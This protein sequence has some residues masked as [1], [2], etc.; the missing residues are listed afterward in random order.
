MMTTKT[1]TSSLRV[2]SQIIAPVLY[3]SALVF[4]RR[5]SSAHGRNS[6]QRRH[7]LIESRT[8]SSLTNRHDSPRIEGSTDML[9]TCLFR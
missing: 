2:V 8:A 1:L 3:L 6:K 5:H 7:E 9:T 4:D